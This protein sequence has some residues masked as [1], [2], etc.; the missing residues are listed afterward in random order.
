[1]STVKISVRVYKEDYDYLREHPVEDIEQR[2]K[3]PYNETVRELVHGF[4]KEL[5]EMRGHDD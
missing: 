4:V 2:R 1:M 3:V 5:K